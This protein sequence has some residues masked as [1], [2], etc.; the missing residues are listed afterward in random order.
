MRR[1]P[2]MLWRAGTPRTDTQYLAYGF[3]RA[4]AF[5]AVG[6]GVASSLVVVLF[7]L[8]ADRENRYGARAFDLEQRHVAGLP[9]RDDQ[10]AQEWVPWTADGL[11][12]G[13]GKHFQHFD[14]LGHCNPGPLCRVE[15]AIEKE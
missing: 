15:I 6:R 14:R 1:G 12:A 8:G 2:A 3:N 10:L 13:E 7:P 4:T 9:E 5:D 11:A